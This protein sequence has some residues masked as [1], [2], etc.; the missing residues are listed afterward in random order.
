MDAVK[1]P[2]GF[3]LGPIRRAD[4]RQD[5]R[6]GK[7]PV[8]DWLATKALQ[9]QE[10]HLTRTKVLRDGGK[11]IVGYYT[12]AMGSVDHVDLPA[13]IRR[14]LP[15]RP[16][17]VATLAWLGVDRTRQRHGI[18]GRLLAAALR[19]CY[20]AGQIF[21]FVAVVL[22]YLDEESKSFYDRNNFLDMPIHTKRMY[23]SMNHLEALMSS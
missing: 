6:S 1:F 15:E 7:T 10:K 12:L 16:A 13:G 19:D 14:R 21:A 22:D 3:Q 23:I 9:S 20:E 5:F 11:A 17:P 18:G 2:D 4:P 8:D